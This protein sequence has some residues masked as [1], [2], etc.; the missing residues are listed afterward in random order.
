MGGCATPNQRRD[1]SWFDRTVSETPQMEQRH[2]E[3][4]KET[5]EHIAHDLSRL[6]IARDED[7]SY[8][9]R[10]RLP[11]VIAAT[12]ILILVAGT[13]AIGYR[14]WGSSFNVPEVEI[15]RATVESGNAGYEILTATGYVVAHRKAAVSPKVSG[16]LEYMGVDVGS[17]ARAGQ[18][19]ARLEHN[20]LDAQLEDARANLANGEAQKAQAEAGIAQ[21]KANLVQAQATQMQTRL[22][23][24]RQI[25]LL[26]DGVTSKADFDNSEAKFKVAAAQVKTAEAQVGSTEA[27]LNSASSQIRSLHAR[28]KLIEAQIEYTNIRAP[29]DG[30]VIS[31]DAELGETVAPAI[32]GGS[33]TRG[34]VVTLVDPK[35]LEVEADINETS[36]VKII[37]GLPAE[38]TLDA[39]PDKKF[40]GEAYQVVPTA[41]R[42]KATVKVKVRFLETDPRVLPDMNA[43][44]TFIQKPAGGSAKEPAK[45][46]VPKASLRQADQKS[47]VLL[48]NAD[49]IHLQEVQAGADFGDRVEIKQGLTGGEAVVVRGA[50]TLG[51]GSKVKVK[52]KD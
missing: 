45:I 13:V 3:T 46:L 44:T 4:L 35:S 12:I 30:I 19:L 37:S 5:S 48:L 14:Y 51:E 1:G 32:F 33:T 47:F 43:K 39:L 7:E 20:D 25:K 29:F 8:S 6:R 11:F 42:Q 23:Y 52:S 2:G 41:D 28:I 17:F 10:R 38:I 31:K 24:D 15:A 18:V 40:R 50:E 21:G 22:D 16:R 34:S 36:I 27:L 26:G 49:R 9:E